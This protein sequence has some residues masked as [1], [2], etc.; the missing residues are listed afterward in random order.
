[1]PVIF[2]RDM[3]TPQGS[4]TLG[5]RF[6][7]MGGKIRMAVVGVGHF[8]RFHAQKVKA[9]EGVELVAVADIDR[10]R[11]REVGDE[12]G[13][14]ALTEGSELVGRVDAVSI[15]V[16]TVA[17]YDV[18]KPFLEEGV[19]LLIEKPITD[20]AESAAELGKLAAAKGVVLQVGHLE[21]FSSATL[22]LESRISRPLYIDSQRVAPYKP[23]GTDVNVILDVMIHDIDLILALVKSPILSIDAA[24]TPVISPLEDIANARVRF[25][26]GCVANITASRVSVKTE[27]KMRIFQPDSYIVVDFSARNLSIM[28]KGAGVAPSGLPNITIEQETYEE[29]DALEREIAAF[30]QAVANN[31]PPL[32]SG[33]DGLRALQAAIMINQSL[34]SHR[35][36]VRSTGYF[37]PGAS[38]AVSGAPGESDG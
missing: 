1:M 15:A 5:R 32:V 2:F 19:H 28:T 22:A 3:F 8:G 31:A 14:E 12:L 13:V 34:E 16:P 35:E 9:L 21:R 7:G 36:F 33:E 24:G 17:H 20:A 29:S 37:E 23:R 4:G 27:R 6:K 18:A 10:A 26:N 30:V 11:A 25:A 38:P